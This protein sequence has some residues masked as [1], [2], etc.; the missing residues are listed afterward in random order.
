VTENL[1]IEEPAHLCR[2]EAAR[3]YG[4]SG[5]ATAVAGG[6]DVAAAVAARLDTAALWRAVQAVVTNARERE[7][8]HLSCV[9]DL[10]PRQIQACRLAAYASMTGIYRIKQAALERLRRTPGLQDLLYSDA[11]SDLAHR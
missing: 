7:V 6:D 4:H 11:K 1:T 2:D 8:L 10:T 3:F 9:L 5:G